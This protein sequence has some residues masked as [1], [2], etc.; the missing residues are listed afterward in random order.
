VHY[1]PI[2]KWVGIS[3]DEPEDRRDRVDFDW[4]D[5]SVVGYISTQRAYPKIIEGRSY[6]GSVIKKVET[7]GDVY[8]LDIEEVLYDLPLLWEK[9]DTLVYGTQIRPELGGLLQHEEMIE[10]HAEGRGIRAALLTSQAEHGLFL[11]PQ[12]E[13]ETRFEELAA[14]WTAETLALSSL[15]D[16]VLHPAYQE[17]L[18]LGLQ[19]VP[20]IL[21]RLEHEPDHWFWALRFI[22][23]ADPAEGT[24]TVHAAAQA[25]TAWGTERGFLP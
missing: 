22:T 11:R 20:S 15:S 24:E 21:T 17:I 14:T 16:M 19:V 2:D 18:G 4:D 7:L 5:S 8:D 1:V 6:G 9:P 10:A 13:V 3:A 23:G 12:D 25:W